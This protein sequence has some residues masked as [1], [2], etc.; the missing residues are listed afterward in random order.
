MC[1]VSRL[2]VAIVFTYSSVA[3]QPAH[4]A[5]AATRPQDRSFF[6]GWYRLDLFP[7]L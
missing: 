5:D 1:A 4:A 7:A 6:E 2:V 3:V